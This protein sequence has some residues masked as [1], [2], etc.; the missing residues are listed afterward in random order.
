MTVRLRIAEFA[1][2]QGLNQ[3]QLAEKSGVSPQVVNRYWNNFTK[4]VSLELFVRLARTLHVSLDDLVESEE[5]T[6]LEE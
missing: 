6:L 1:E 5:E 3:S 4:S 2:A